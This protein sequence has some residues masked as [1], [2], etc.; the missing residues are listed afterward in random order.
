MS[1]CE[2]RAAFELISTGTSPFGSSLLGVSAD[3]TDAYFFT[4]DK[5]V[6]QDENGTRVKIYDA[7][8]S[9]AASRMSRRPIRM[10]GLG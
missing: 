5:L 7:R 2:S 3:G 1:H 10:Q 4:R 6:T 8:V 9:S